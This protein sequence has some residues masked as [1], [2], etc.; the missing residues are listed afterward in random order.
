MGSAEK[1]INRFLKVPKD[2]TWDELASVLGEYGYESL[3]TGKTG[4]SRR[5]F[6]DDMPLNK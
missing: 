3:K 4:G 5:K 1:L 6:V 2:F